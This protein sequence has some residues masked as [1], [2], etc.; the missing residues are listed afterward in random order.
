M[1]FSLALRQRRVDYGLTEQTLAD[2]SI[3]LAKNYLLGLAVTSIALL[4]LVG[5]ARRWRTWWP[6]IAGGACAGLVL[7]GSYVYPVLVEPLF[8][9]FSS[10]P[11]GDTRSQILALADDQG[12][13]V[14]DVLI[15]D[16]SRRT[17]TLNAYVSGFG[18][19]RRVVVYDNLIESQPEDQVLSV[20]AHELAHAKHDDVLVGTGLGAFA[21]LIGVGL[22]GLIASSARVR[23]RSGVGGLDDPRSVALVLGL[24]TVATLLASPVQ[25]TISRHVELRADLD[26]L[27]VS[28]PEAMVDL[29]RDLC[30]RAVCDPTPPAWSQFWFGS[31]PTVLERVTIAG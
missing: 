15:A 8:N 31:H 2:W 29:Q 18:D 3:D 26:A 19:T 21:T 23:R 1:P 22:L 14:D 24:M 28:S 12:V 20:V 11:D 17:T 5:C 4:V 7:A 27:R 30:L 25:N 13:A 10:M 16:A 6:A 9:D